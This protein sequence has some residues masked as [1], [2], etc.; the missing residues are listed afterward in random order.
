MKIHSLTDLWNSRQIKSSFELTFEL[1]L[2]SGTHSIT[3]V[4][5]STACICVSKYSKFGFSVDVAFVRN[6][7]SICK[8]SQTCTGN[9]KNRNRIQVNDRS[10]G[11][12]W[13]LQHIATVMRSIRPRNRISKI[14]P[15]NKPR[16]IFK[17][18]LFP[19]LLVERLI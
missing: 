15:T 14:F 8:L 13:H 18:N 1:S 3:M 9:E 6:S 4:L 16:T 12:M 19:V 2:N 11:N 17:S 7:E 10:L 5:C